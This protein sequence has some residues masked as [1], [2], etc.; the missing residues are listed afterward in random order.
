MGFIISM[1][2]TGGSILP[3]VSSSSSAK[4]Y[5]KKPD[6]SKRPSAMP[7]SVALMA[8]VINT[9]KTMMRSSGAIRNGTVM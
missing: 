1:E 2:S 6:K 8:S 7:N 5:L 3:T 9:L 4:E